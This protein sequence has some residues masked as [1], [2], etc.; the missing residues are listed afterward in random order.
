MEITVVHVGVDVVEQTLVVETFAFGFVVEVVADDILEWNVVKFDFVD[1][2]GEAFFFVT[3]NHVIDLLLPRGFQRLKIFR[4]IED[5]P[6]IFSWG[7]HESFKKIV[8]GVRSRLL[9]SL[10]GII[11]SNGLRWRIT[12]FKI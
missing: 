12:S 11:I 4:I 10:S 9:Q 1:F 6:D 3:W 5:F 7:F 8:I 2:P